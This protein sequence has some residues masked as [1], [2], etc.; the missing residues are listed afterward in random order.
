MKTEFLNGYLKEIVFM[1]QPENIFNEENTRKYVYYRT[2]Y[3]I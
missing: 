2:P 3:M 1:S